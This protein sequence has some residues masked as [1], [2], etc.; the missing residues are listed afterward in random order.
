VTV[1]YR[2]AL[3]RTA[4][5]TEDG[6]FTGSLQ[7]PG[8]WRYANTIALSA[9]LNS[10]FSLKLSHTLKYLNQPVGGFRSADRLVSAALVA[11]F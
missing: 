2:L 9:S 8:D 4:E 1:A 10:V 7:E 6:A 5:L 11:K 3:G